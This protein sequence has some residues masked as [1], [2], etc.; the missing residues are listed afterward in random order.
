MT[1][2]NK[3]CQ[4]YSGKDIRVDTDEPETIG[5]LGVLHETYKEFHWSAKTAHSL[6]S[7]Y[8]RHWQWLWGTV[9]A[10][11]LGIAAIIWQK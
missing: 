11:F 5:G 2:L 8:I 7:F 9:T 3:F 6:V 10:V 1:I 4:W